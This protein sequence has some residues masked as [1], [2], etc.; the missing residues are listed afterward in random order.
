M[1]FEKW[2]QYV[3][4]GWE[5]LGRDGAREKHYFKAL[6]LTE[7]QQNIRELEDELSITFPEEFLTFYQEVGVGFLWS[8]EPRKKG[9]Y[10][11]FSPG[12]L[13]ELYFEPEDE[14]AEDLWMTFRDRAW[15]NLEDGALLAFCDYGD[16]D[17]LIYLSLSDGAVCYL[18]PSRRIADSLEEF[19]D[20]LDEKVDYFMTP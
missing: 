19:L 1:Q 17:S 16:E 15:E 11:V 9:H 2:R 12:E 5:G 3:H 20:R 18:S 6:N 14:G 4:S 8:G 13:L 7:E 10:R